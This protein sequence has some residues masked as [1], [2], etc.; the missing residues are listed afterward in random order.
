MK[1]LDTV[2]IVCAG[3]LTFKANKITWSLLRKP[4]AAEPCLTASTAYSTWWMRPWGDQV[5]TSLSYWLRN[6]K[7]W[8]AKISP[9]LLHGITLVRWW[10]LPW[11]QAE[12]RNKYVKEKGMKENEGQDLLL[13]ARRGLKIR[14]RR[15][16]TSESE[17]KSRRFHALGE[18]SSTLHKE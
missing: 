1:S 12:A 13:S 10:D 2:Y 5:V 8:E 9:L 7:S 15:D 18:V 16:W 17:N 6:Y 14:L 3:W 4:M 11:L